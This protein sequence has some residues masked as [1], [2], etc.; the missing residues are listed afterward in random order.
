MTPEESK[1]ILIN[2]QEGLLNI[3]GLVKD[4]PQGYQFKVR[5][6]LS[7]AETV[8]SMYNDIQHGTIPDIL[9]E[10]SEKIEVLEVP[11][12]VKQEELPPRTVLKIE[13]FDLDD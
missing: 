1:R 3:M 2:V 13:D 9:T 7:C 11:A 5:E 4:L 6:M 8:V 12:E 10:K